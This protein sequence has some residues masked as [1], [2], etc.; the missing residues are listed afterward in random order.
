M[1]LTTLDICNEGQ[2]MN[3]FGQILYNDNIIIR[4]VKYPQCKRGGGVEGEGGL[5]QYFTSCYLTSCKLWNSN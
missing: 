4:D 2:S 5:W 3:N 1:K